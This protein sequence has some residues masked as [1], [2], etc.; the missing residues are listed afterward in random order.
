M[1]GI[2][3]ALDKPKIVAGQVSRTPVQMEN[4]KEAL[5]E[6]LQGHA[7]GTVVIWMMQ[8]LVW[9]TW[10]GAALSFVDDEEVLADY[11][12]EIR[13]FNENEELHLRCC[14]SQLTGRWLKD[15][16]AEASEYVDAIAR[17][18]GSREEADGKL[19]LADHPRKLR[20]DLPVQD[21]MTATYYGLV[22]RNYIGISPVTHQ[23]GYRDYRFVRIA[24]ADVKEG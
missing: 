11:W 14:G 19:Q 21:D 1:S 2:E 18:W 8:G 15:D 4:S 7:P 6:E 24:P 12:Q 10:D 16:G 22:T 5:L 23:A 17:L 20:L 3:L 13:A 9:G